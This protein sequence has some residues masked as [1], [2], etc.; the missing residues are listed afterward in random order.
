MPDVVPDDDRLPETDPADRLR[1]RGIVQLIGWAIALGVLPPV[2]HN[3]YRGHWASVAV[4]LATGAGALVAL[5][6]SRR[7]RVD[8]AVGVL[9]ASVEACAGG[10]VVVSGQ[11]LHN[12]AMMLF[13]AT[14]VVAGLVL[15]RRAF[16]LVTAGTIALVT[17]IGVAEILGILAT[18][19]S[20]FTHAPILGDAAV[21]LGV[22]GIA[23]GLLAE[24]VRTSL[25]RA[26]QHEARLEAVNAELVRQSRR[27]QAS[28]ERFR[29]LID[30]A[31]DGILIGN[32]EGRIIGVNRRMRELTGCTGEELIGRPLPDLFP[33]EEMRRAPLRCD[34]V[35]AG[36]TVVTERVVVRKDGTTVPVEMSSK[37]M[38]D[39]KYHSFFRDI[40]ERRRAA[41]ERARLQDELRHAQKMEAVGR[42]AGGMAHDFNNMLMVIGSSVAV[43]L[44]DVE[45]GSRAHR[46]LTEVEGAAER[47]ATLTRQLLAFSRKAPVAPRVL[48]L[49]ELVRNVAT[50]VA[51][52]AGAEVRLD[53]AAP[54]GLGLVRVDAGLVEQAVINLATN[55]RDAMPG[56]GR[57]GLVLS[58]VDLDDVGALALGLKP[59]PHVAL[60]VTDNGTGMTDEV[61]QH[62]FEP[63]FTTKPAG[64]GT[65]LG[66]AMVYGAA[67]QS[68][69]G[70]EVETRLG[71]G[72]TFRL[73]FPRATPART[74]PA[75]P[76]A[77]LAGRAPVDPA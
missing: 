76:P 77:A 2:L 12:V 65:G 16:A 6:F 26:Q 22:T 13:P 18:P 75:C 23:V 53:V 14:L 4:L 71:R 61:R 66:L 8:A 50:M 58:D 38:P 32:E 48:D 70:I 43:A 28:E 10:L 7:G 9:V 35:A 55:A 24:S 56:G 51:G 54:D 62:L 1:Q 29:S 15:E 34:R 25:A 74:L 36:E 44:R 19:L 20:R 27:L 73:Y 3:A 42:V 69:G 37:R 40:T 39:G 33:G 64:R 5:V 63:F 30:L 31:V 17:A 11:G 67:R 45:A 21:I 60:A 49:G 41:E 68:G 46:C 59:G 57:L 47:A 52:I 72:T